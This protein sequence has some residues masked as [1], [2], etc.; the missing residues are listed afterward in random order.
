MTI[1]FVLFFTLY[2]ILVIVLFAGW[3]KAV[4]QKPGAVSSLQATVVVPARNEARNIAR[5][6]DD[7]KH[8]THA[9]FDVIVVDDHSEDDTAD[10][11]RQHLG[12]NLHI[13]LATSAGTGKKAALTQGVQLA[14]GKVIITTDADCRAPAEWIATLLSC[15]ENETVQMVFGGVAILGGNY[16][17]SLQSLEF[18][19]LIGSGAATMAL[20]I[21]TMC[22]GANLAFR[23]D[24][25]ET[26]GGYEG[27]LHIPSGDDEFLLRKIARHF[28]GGIAFSGDERTVVTTA[29]S[30]TLRDFIHQRI[31]WAGK[32]R[33]HQSFVSKALALFVAGFQALVF[34]LP[35]MVVMQRIDVGVAAGLWVSKAV[36]EYFFLRSVSH[37]L[38]LSWNWP[39]FLSLQLLYPLYILLIGVFSNFHT[40]EWKGRKLKSLTISHNEAKH[41]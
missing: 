31:R 25:F 17:S 19:S 30:P 21:P 22:N 16:F 24:A 36:L 11:V 3:K 34:L 41:F 2:F 33:H 10:I 7:L 20:G 8:Q 38:R 32:W 27:N 1:V 29:P 12:K 26:V 5:L 18:A 4:A 13:R 15:F 37:I 39:A 6:L 35:A 28:P 23:K 9:S 14:Q 40:F